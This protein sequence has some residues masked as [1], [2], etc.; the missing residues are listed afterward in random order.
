MTTYNNRLGNICIFC[1]G[2]IL[3]ALAVIT[4]SVLVWLALI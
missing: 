4:A 1:T 3:A 2:T